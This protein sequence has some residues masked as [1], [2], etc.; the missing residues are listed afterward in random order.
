MADV[1]EMFLDTEPI[2]TLGNPMFGGRDVQGYSRFNLAVWIESTDLTLRGLIDFDLALQ[3]FLLCGVAISLLAVASSRS[4]FGP[5]LKLFWFPQVL[6]LMTMLVCGKVAAVDWLAETQSTPYYIEIAILAFRVLWWVVPAWLFNIGVERFF[7]TPLE[8]RTG[9]DVPAVVRIFFAGLVYTLALL[10][11]TAF[12]FDQKVTSLLATSGVLAMIIGLIIQ[13]NLSIIFAGIAIN[14]ERPFRMGDWIRVG[15][16]KPGKVVGITWRT[17]RIETPDKNINC[18]PNSVASD[19]SVVNLSY[20]VDAYRSQLMVHVDPGA[21]P[22]WVEKNPVRR[23][24]LDRRRSEG[25]HPGRPVPRGQGVVGG[26]FRSFLL[27][28]LSAKRRRQCGG[29][30]GH[31]PQPALRRLRIGHP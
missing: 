1:A 22:Q 31:R 24:D 7:W 29:L 21:K 20:P 19:S 3:M 4:R 2:A 14:M 18:V 9:R 16:F 12:V 17:T 25:S 23:R 26:I 13:M 28:R 10:G 6:A 15:D 30:A 5:Y 11:V 8:Q 27:P